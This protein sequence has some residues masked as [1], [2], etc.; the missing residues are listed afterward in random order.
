MAFRPVPTERAK[1]TDDQED[2]ALGSRRGDELP[3]ELR[4]REDRL[5]V[6]E[7]AMERLEAEAREKAEAQQGHQII[8][9]AEGTT[10]ANDKQQAGAMATKTR[11]T[12][13][14]AGIAFL[15]APEEPSGQPQQAEQEQKHHQ[16]S[17]DPVAGSAARVQIAVSPPAVAARPPRS[18][19]LASSVGL[20]GGSAAH[21]QT[22]TSA[23]AE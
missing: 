14:S 16:A 3:D 20:I 19:S 18:P 15:K 12:L 8:V 17:R 13:E 21:L 23:A 1:Q 5:A 4:R 10:D 9:E 22:V 11:E 7:A 2:A 6:I